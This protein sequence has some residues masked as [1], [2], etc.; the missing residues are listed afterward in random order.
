MI[1]LN[2]FYNVSSIY[3]EAN[4]WMVGHSLGGALSSLVGLTFGLPTVTFEAPGEKLAA[5]RLHLPFT[6]G[7]PNDEAYIWHFGHT[8]D[9]I[10]MGTCNGPKS[11][12]WY[13]GYAMETRCH[14]GLSC[15]YDIVADKGWRMAIGTHRIKQ[16]I[17]IIKDYEDL[18]KCTVYPDCADCP[19]WN[20]YV[21]FFLLPILLMTIA[22]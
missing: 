3:P 2:I 6:P 8:A 15:I 4:V 13:G 14:S 7:L 17:D 19:E 18:P 10:F 11:T 1:A 12:C 22:L 9:P 21:Y 5:K 20:F 16:V